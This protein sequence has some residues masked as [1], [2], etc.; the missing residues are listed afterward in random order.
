MSSTAPAPRPTAR[1][2]RPRL[3][4]RARG[5]SLVE[6]ALVFPLFFTVLLG[7]IEFGL[8]FNA[9][10]SVNN[11]SRTAVLTATEAGTLVGADCVILQAIE[12]DIRAPVDA[13]RITTVDIYYSDKNGVQIGSEKSTWNRTGSTSCTVSGT[14]WNIPY[15]RTANGYPESG[16]CNVLAGCSVAHPGV[17]TVGVKVTYIHQWVTPL[18]A[19]IGSGT[20]FTIVRSNAMRMEPVL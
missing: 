7:V 3:V 11:A 4:G 1:R 17:D 5:Q 10:L 13:A 6:F 14:T 8:T 16:R 12:D 9:I 20:S 2:G 15:T 18:H 19:F